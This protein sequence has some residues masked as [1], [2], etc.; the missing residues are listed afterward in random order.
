[1][2]SS[3]VS[4]NQSVYSTMSQEAQAHRVKQLF[5]ELPSDRQVCLFSLHY[6][7][8]L[9]ESVVITVLAS[10]CAC[11]AALTYVRDEGEYV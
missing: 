11:C 9:C 3:G 2:A 1:M 10:Y 4:S 6:A 5:K 7:H 8:F